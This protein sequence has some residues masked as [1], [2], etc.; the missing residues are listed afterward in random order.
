MAQFIYW[1]NSLRLAL[2]PTASEV[3]VLG[4]F[5]V[6]HSRSPKVWADMKAL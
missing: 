6:R 1:D 2:W 5:L 3:E 4:L